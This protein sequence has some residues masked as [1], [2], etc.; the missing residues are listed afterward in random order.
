MGF[1]DLLAF[2]IIAIS[3]IIIAGM[4]IIGYNKG[5]NEGRRY[6]EKEIE[7]I[8]KKADNTKI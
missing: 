3:F 2:G 6:K 8:L 4:W 5:F 1:K 7:N